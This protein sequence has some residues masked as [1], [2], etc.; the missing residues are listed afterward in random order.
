MKKTVLLFMILFSMLAFAKDEGFGGDTGIGIGVVDV[1]GESKAALR[2]NFNPEFKIS[3]FGIGAKLGLYMGDG[4]PVDING[5]GK[6]DYKDIDFGLRYMEWDGDIVKARY[7]TLDDFTLGHGTLVYNYSNN[8]KISLR[9]GLHDPKK[10]VGTDVFFP[11]EKDIFG[12][13]V[14]KEDQPKAMGARVYVRPLKIAGLET[15]IIKNLEFGA[16]YAADVRDKFNRTVNKEGKLATTTVGTE[17]VTNEYNGKLTG[18]T[19]EVALPLIEDVIVP[20]YDRVT[21]KGERDKD[22]VLDVTTGK[23]SK[24]VYGDHFGVIGKVSVVNYKFEYRNIDKGLTPGYFGK[25]YEVKSTQNLEKIFSNDADK[26]IG[27]YFGELSANFAGLT[28]VT[29]SYED[30]DE[31]GLNPHIFGQMD[32]TPSEKF[33]AHLSYDQIDFG[34]DRHSDDFLNDDTVIKARLVGPASMFGIPGPFV[35]NAD[36]KQTYY[37]NDEKDKYIP[38]RTYTMGMSFIW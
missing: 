30:Y 12:A 21:V 33:Q 17:T 26:K 28:K 38:S 6:E 22:A 2:L 24:T 7:G 37:F 15:P 9:L 16:T 20:Y 19:Y 32:V 18:I 36:I 34:S 1:N 4:I 10:R 8:E 14:E 3:K 25:F 13:T 27:G 35:V 5:D 29:A 31:E 11:L 23:A